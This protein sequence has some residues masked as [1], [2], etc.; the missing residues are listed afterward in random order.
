MR[1]FP[2]AAVTVAAAGFVAYAA[3]CPAAQVW[4]RGFHR[5]PRQGRRLA[6]TFDDGPSDQTPAFVELLERYGVRATFFVCGA[7][8]ERRPEIARA[9]L[10]AGHE[11]GNHT[12]AHPLLLRLPPRRVRA[13]VQRAQRVIEDRLGVQPTMFRAPYGI[14]APGLAG[15]LE[16]ENLLAVRWTV[17]GND[18]RLPAERIAGRILRGVSPGGIVCL[19]DGDRILPTADRRPTLRALEAALPRLLDAGYSMV[20]TSRLYSGGK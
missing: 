19:H 14:H 6:L 13:E 15:A 2:A 8:V 7:N 4:G 5:G 3:A 11:I 18:W 10:A 1:A 12:H 17:I 16:H 9:T 20:E